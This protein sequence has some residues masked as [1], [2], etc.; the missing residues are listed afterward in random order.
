MSESTN[1]LSTQQPHWLVA[2]VQPCLEKKT[3]GRLKAMGI[4]CYLPIQSKVH[5]WSDRL[6][7]VDRLVIPMIIFVRVTQQERPLPLTLQAVSRYMILR[8][9]SAP[10]VIPDEQ[11]EKFRFMLDY[12]EEAVEFCGT[13]LTPGDSVRVIKGSLAG[14][15]GEL[16]TVEGHSKVVVR[17]GM[18]GW[19]QV[20]MKV[21]FVEKTERKW[22]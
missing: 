18:L 2:Y 16:L 14:L 13:P 22:M 8:G 1:I 15:E 10:A 12:S 20:E 11:M 4:E 3:A 7:R 6:K 19:A 21:G 17:L 9:S 5:Q